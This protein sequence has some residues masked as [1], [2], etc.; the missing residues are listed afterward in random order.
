MFPDPVL[1]ISRRRLMQAAA[2]AT[3]T[4]VAGPATAETAPPSCPPQDTHG[5]PPERLAVLARGFNLPD[6]MGG[7]RTRQ[8]D[9]AVLAHL[10]DRGFTH[11]RLPVLPERLM[12]AFSPAP[13]IAGDLPTLDLAIDALLAI[14]FAVSLDLHP[15]GDLGDLHR[16]APDRAL[17]LIDALWAELA[18][19]YAG[20]NPDR[21]F[22]EVLNEPGVDAA[23]WARQGPQLATTIRR[24]APS[25]TIIYAPPN[26]QRI[27]ALLTL[28]LLALSNVIYAVHFYDP[29][30]F[31]HQGL[32]WSE[33]PLRYLHG[34]PFPVRAVDVRVKRLLRELTAD[35]HT[36]A[37][38]MLAEEM[39]R[40]W[41]ATR[42]GI[43]IG[44]A[45]AWAAQRRR[46]VILNE[47]GVLRWKAPAED[48]LRWLSLVR[49]T[50]ERNC[51]GWAHWDYADAFGLA[52]REGDRQVPD[53]ATLAALLD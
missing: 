51:I 4:S 7:R 30:V 48:R 8:P 3:L 40:P 10:F 14:G 20:R 34:V 38:A 49:H 45:A 19:R 9:V 46:P 32:D 39:D 27:D 31:T 13:A 22:F 52:R 18:A 33:G 21:L 24:A 1:R 42:I 36:K 2:A 17:G 53:P 16:S 44:S 15:G 43:E 47:F 11:I 6:W 23:I 35:G 28:D 37:A 12:P 5:V 41:T 50:A 29:M 26:F 25:H